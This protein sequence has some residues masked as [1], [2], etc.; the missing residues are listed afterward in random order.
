MVETAIVLPLVIFLILGILQLSLMHQA[1]MLTRYAAFKATRAGALH[2]AKIDIMKNAAF[3]VLLPIAGR[4]NAESFYR[5]DSPEGYADAWM[6]AAEASQPGG[7]PYV[8]V[9]ICNPTS[10]AG[11]TDATDFDDPEFAGVDSWEGY[12]RT[13]LHVQVTFYYRLMIPFANMVLWWIT[14]GQENPIMLE[15]N[16]MNNYDPQNYGSGRAIE[17]TYQA[18]QQGIYYIPIRAHYAYRMQSNALPDQLPAENNCRVPFDRADGKQAVKRQVILRSTN[19]SGQPG[20][21]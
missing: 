5:T 11:W 3:G 14:Y 15:V 17:D 8:Q 9:T 6:Q 10:Q 12:A 7:V 4:V 13:R 1:R 21:P 19:P 16:R 18:A 20:V 2:R